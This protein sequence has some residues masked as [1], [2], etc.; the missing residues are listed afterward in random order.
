MVW[1]FP[2]DLTKA[3]VDTGKNPCDPLGVNVAQIG[4][5]VPP[6]PPLIGETPRPSSP[7]MEHDTCCSFWFFLSFSFSAPYAL[8][9]T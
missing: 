1:F 4:L 6:K 9:T 2:V 8:L 7:G 3:L 5:G